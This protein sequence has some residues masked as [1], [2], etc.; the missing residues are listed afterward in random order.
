MNENWIQNLFQLLRGLKIEEKFALLSGNDELFD[1][2]N[3]WFE[4]SPAGVRDNVISHFYECLIKL[5]HQIN[6][7]A[8]IN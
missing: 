8:I 6:E 4:H 1:R 3:L 7:N 5:K 2:Q